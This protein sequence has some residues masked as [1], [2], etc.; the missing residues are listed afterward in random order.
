M[1]QENKDGVILMVGKFGFLAQHCFTLILPKYDESVV[2]VNIIEICLRGFLFSLHLHILTQSSFQ[3]GDWLKQEVNC[4]HQERQQ[5]LSMD[6][7]VLLPHFILCHCWRI[8]LTYCWQTER[9]SSE[10][11]SAS[12]GWEQCPSALD[13]KTLNGDI[14]KCQ[15]CSSFVHILFIFLLN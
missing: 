12:L 9:F 15:C 6:V 5:V 7:G 3:K 13:T 1:L 8:F 14:F 2:F 4:S 11:P 10:G